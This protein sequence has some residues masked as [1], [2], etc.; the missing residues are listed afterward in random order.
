MHG[1][2]GPNGM[3][4][5]AEQGNRRFDFRLAARE[6]ERAIRILE[7]LL[8]RTADSGEEPDK[9][10]VSELQAVI[11]GQQRALPIHRPRWMAGEDRGF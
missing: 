4:G 3:A 8:R 5:I 11:T 1:Y 2:R 10:S 9:H 7:G 6:R